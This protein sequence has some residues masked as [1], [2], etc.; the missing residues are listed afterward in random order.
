MHRVAICLILAT[1]M[2]D[3]ISC[4]YHLSDGHDTSESVATPLKLYDLRRSRCQ[5]PLQKL[6]QYEVGFNQIERYDVS[7]PL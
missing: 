3:I 1:L 5:A 6:S 4:S 7:L 2:P